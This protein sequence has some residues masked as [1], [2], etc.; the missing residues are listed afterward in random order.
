MNLD[1]G[2]LPTALIIGGLIGTFLLKNTIGSKFA[3]IITGAGFMSIGAG[4]ALMINGSTSSKAAFVAGGDYFPT[5]IT[6]TRFSSPVNNTTNVKPENRFDK[7]TN[8]VLPPSKYNSYDNYVNDVI[9][10]E[11]KSLGLDNSIGNYPVR[12]NPWDIPALNT[13]TQFDPIRD[14]NT[15]KFIATTSV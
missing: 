4:L 9:L 8:Y 10:D 6:N 11:I 15:V 13:R 2:I 3:P 7:Q 14:S 1:N 5:E 12:V